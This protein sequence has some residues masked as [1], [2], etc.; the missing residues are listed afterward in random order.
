MAATNADLEGRV[1]EVTWRATKLRT[2]AGNFIIVPNNLVSQQAIMN[3]SERVAP[4][5]LELDI[6]ASY[7]STPGDVKVLDV[8]P[9]GKGAVVR[10]LVAP[11]RVPDAGKPFRVT[12]P[13]FAHR[14]EKGHSLRLVV[15]G[16]SVN[17]RGGLVP[18]PVTV[19][20]GSASQVLSLPLV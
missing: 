18:A 9:D 6:G 17:Y 10:D 11:V 3:F 19:A 4:T 16:G 15:A 7:L 14:F 1:A 2:K 13:A 20:T 8:G 5:R 12:L